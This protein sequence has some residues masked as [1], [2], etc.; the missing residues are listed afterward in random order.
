MRAGVT[1]PDGVEPLRLDLAQLRKS[2][3]QKIFERP[4][5]RLYP[6]DE[7]PVRFPADGKKIDDEHKA[8]EGTAKS[9]TSLQK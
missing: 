7:R 5:A 8:K 4:G 2:G 3:R 1:S 9:L 6:L